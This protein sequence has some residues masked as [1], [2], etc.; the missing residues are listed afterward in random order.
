MLLISS[1]A[2]VIGI[3]LSIFTSRSITSPL[4]QSVEISHELADGKLKKRELTPFNDELGEMS[5]AI[6]STSINLYTLIANIQQSSG[7]ISLYAKQLLTPIDEVDKGSQNQSESLSH[8]N[9]TL[10]H[11]LADIDNLSNTSEQATE[12][13]QIAHD[14]AKDG[15]NRIQLTSEEFKTISNSILEST[16]LVKA[17][18]DCAITVRKM[19]ESISEIADQTNLLTLNAAVEAARAGESGRGCSVVADEVRALP[20]RTS[21]ATLDINEQMDGIDSQTQKSVTQISK[22][23]EQLDSGVQLIE[24]MLEPLTQLKELKLIIVKQAQASQ[25]IAKD[26]S[27]TD[28]FST[29]NS[30]AVKS[31]LH[32]S[33]Q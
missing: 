18:R 19:V 10:D 27:T 12:Q 29:D 32:Y 31:A 7:N 33:Q 4:K 3:L 8:I 14:L 16:E 30:M 2:L 22:G 11:F 24:D 13:A 6:K 9:Q 1:A 5:H 23:K 17:L 21:Q 15:L 20:N 28:Q 25:Q 26:V